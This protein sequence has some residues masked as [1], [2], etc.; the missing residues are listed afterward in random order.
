M[1]ST[2]KFQIL[3][4]RGSIPKKLSINLAVPI[5]D[6]EIN[7]AG[8]SIGVWEAPSF[9][10]HIEI[11]LNSTKEPAFTFRIGKRI[12]TAFTKLFITVPVG[13][14]GTMELIYGTGSPD[15]IQF[16]SQPNYLDA[17]LDDLLAALNANNVLLGTI[18]TTLG[19]LAL[20]LAELQ[21]DVAVENWG[22]EITVGNGVVVQICAANAN[23]KGAVIQSKQVNAGLVYLGFDNTV[24]STKWG[25]QLI[26]SASWNI[27]DYRGPVYAIASA[28]G[29]L[30][31]FA[32]W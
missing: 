14:A 18:N 25:V 15:L 12:E 8:D 31:S 6:L 11:K 13:L 26:A 2:E 32:E 10:E 7:V 17:G 22:N 21:G 4:D 19:S 9:N 1:K 29:Q 30:V 5:T 23:R 3:H 28:A 16:L 27:G 24:S 20:I